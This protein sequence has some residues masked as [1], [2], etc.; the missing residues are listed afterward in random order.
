[1]CKTIIF[2][3]IAHW[4]VN[5][6]SFSQQ[7]IQNKMNIKKTCLLLFS[8]IF[9]I[10][11]VNAQITPPR[12]PFKPMEMINAKY[13]WY[14]TVMD[15][16]VVS[17]TMD[18][19]N[20]ILRYDINPKIIYNDDYMITTFT[21]HDSLGKRGPF[22]IKNNLKTGK[23]EWLKRYDG[24]NT[25]KQDVPIMSYLNEN[26][27]LVVLG[28]SRYG[29]IKYGTP[30]EELF[31]S[32]ALSLRR[33]DVTNGTELYSL[34]ADKNDDKTA[35]FFLKQL[36]PDYTMHIFKGKEENEYIYTKRIAT[37][38][39]DNI[40]W[41]RFNE[42]GQRISEN[43]TVRLNTNDYAHH[44]NIFEFQDSLFFYLDEGYFDPDW[45]IRIFDKS[46][47]LKKEIPLKR[48]HL[49][50][51]NVKVVTI[52]KN[53]FTLQSYYYDNKDELVVEVYTYNYEG[54]ML[55]YVLLPKYFSS[56]YS[57]IYLED[58]GQ[59]LIIAQHYLWPVFKP[60]ISISLSNKTGGIDLIKEIRLKD[61]LKGLYPKDIR[62]FDDD[63]V[64][65]W[66]E[67]LVSGILA[68]GTVV[69]FDPNARAN[70]IMRI[71]LEELGVIINA[72]DSHTHIPNKLII[73]PNPATDKIKIS[74]NEGDA[75][76]FYST[77]GILV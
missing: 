53:Y 45:N 28:C 40:M 66:G 44:H 37:F 25:P 20:D 64:V 57:S 4:I 12:K 33:F 32:S 46:F 29:D 6:L 17:S 43:D 13:K 65:N 41:Y 48:N 21:M 7:K 76:E 3:L 59:T 62:R 77:D 47:N 51:R 42:K 36:D 15:S 55:D 73:S 11:H 49:L 74:G 63:L 24:Y 9:C 71:S 14:F 5:G 72:T 26:D 61:K 19:I 35:K 56:G 23:I 22:I 1:M 60:E 16:S 39:K 54:E 52:E 70:T 67:V 2:F 34:I 68:D 75:L 58:L 69:P 38:D 10:Q 8:I 18:G 50:K 30:Y 31:D 27:E